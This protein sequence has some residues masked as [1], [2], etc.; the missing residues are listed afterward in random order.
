MRGWSTESTE[1]ETNTGTEAEAD[2]EKEGKDPI[3]SEAFIIVE[4]IS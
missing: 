3:E 4:I 1:V 2:A